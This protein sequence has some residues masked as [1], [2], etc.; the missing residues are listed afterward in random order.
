MDSL[1]SELAT[2]DQRLRY[3]TGLTVAQVPQLRLV[4]A[5]IPRWWP[6]TPS[7]AFPNMR[8]RGL[9]IRPA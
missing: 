5:S 9:R 6:G 4:A 8:V 1:P 7:N 3:A 2:F